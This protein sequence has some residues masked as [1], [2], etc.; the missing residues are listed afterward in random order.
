[1]LTAR[2][3]ILCSEKVDMGEQAEAVLQVQC[4]FPVPL[5]KCKLHICHCMTGQVY[6]GG[7]LQTHHCGAQRI[8]APEVRLYDYLGLFCKRIKT[9]ESCVCTVE[10]V[11]VPVSALP[12]AG[13]SGVR[14]KRGGGFAEEH[15]LRQYIPGDD[16]RQIHWKLTAKTGKIVVREPLEYLHTNRML[17]VV[18]S[19][20]PDQLDRKL[21]RLK[22]LSTAMLDRNE[23]H[24]VA[25][26]TGNGLER[27]KILDR[28]SL[29]AMLK[30]VLSAPLASVDAAMPEVEEGASVMPIGGD[31]DG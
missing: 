2:F 30:K 6:T 9:V 23:G 7:K 20:T 3:Q 11:A 10:P 17:T 27:F 1:M 29:E 31:S 19:G 24:E 28:E 13:S 12:E 4:R 5:Y 16:L 14:P 21:G 15:D 26:L 22:W 8:S 25:A 18:L